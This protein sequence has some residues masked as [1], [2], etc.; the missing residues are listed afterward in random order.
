MIWVAA[1]VGAQRKCVCRLAVSRALHSTAEC[2][3]SGRS[4]SWGQVTGAEQPTGWHKGVRLTA[5]WEVW[6]QQVRW[7]RLIW[8]GQAL[9]RQTL[10]R[11]H[12]SEGQVVVAG[13]L[14]TCCSSTER[15]SHSRTWSGVGVSSGDKCLCVSAS[16][17]PCSRLYIHC[18]G[19]LPIILD[20]FLPFQWIVISITASN[21]FGLYHL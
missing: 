9:G 19:Q 17:P 21:Y 13:P 6:A 16:S 5:G 2:G 20:H 11:Q 8:C 1:T 18:P 4:H 10:H 14:G 3:S 7:R 15:R 12:V